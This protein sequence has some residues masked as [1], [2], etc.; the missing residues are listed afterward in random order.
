MRVGKLVVYSKDSVTSRVIQHSD[1]ILRGS[2]VMLNFR[3]SKTDQNGRSVSLIFASCQN[4]KTFPVA[5]LCR[6]I[7]QRPCIDGPLFCHFN[8]QPLT[9]FQFSSVLAK[10]IKFL[11]IKQVVHPHSFR[12][13]A[14]T[15]AC[16]QNI[17]DE[18]MQ[19]M[20]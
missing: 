9:R 1:V 11:G 5:L 18:D 10:V 15:L 4:Q 14:T 2:E 16:Q 12:I 19:A 13:G 7:Q 6:Y 20:E 17:S 3:F 8:G